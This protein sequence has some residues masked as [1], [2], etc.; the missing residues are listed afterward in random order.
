MSTTREYLT[1]VRTYYVRTDGNDSNNGL[2]DSSSGAFLTV[3]RAISELYKLDLGNYGA[4]IQVR[5]GTYSG[6]QYSAV[7]TVWSPWVGGN[8]LNGPSGLGAPVTIRGDVNTPSNVVFSATN[9]SCLRSSYGGNINIEG[10]RCVVNTSGTA[11][12]ASALGQITISGAMDFGPSAGGHISANQNGKVIA[13]GINYTV[14]G[15]AKYHYSAFGAGSIEAQATVSLSNGLTFTEAFAWA[16]TLG[17]LQA[18]NTYPN[19]VATGKTYDVSFN[20][21][22]DSGGQGFPGSVGGSQSTGG[23]RR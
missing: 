2:G 15:G 19:Y 22:I 8:A 21:V 3:Q 9:G 5:P 1:A 18:I 17:S 7:A 4:L 11:L 20:A 23:E 14:S 10:V 12:Y 13:A 6:P 16:S